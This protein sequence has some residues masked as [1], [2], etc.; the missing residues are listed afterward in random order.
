MDKRSLINRVK[1]LEAR[2]GHKQ[3]HL[4]WMERDEATYEE[5]YTVNLQA[6]TVEQFKAWRDSLPKQDRV[7]VLYF[8]S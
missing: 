2:E 6:L 8:L 5:V 4:V 3:V 7:I 1:A